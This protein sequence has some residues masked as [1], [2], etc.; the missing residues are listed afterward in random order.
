MRKFECEIVKKWKWIEEREKENPCLVGLRFEKEMRNERGN[1]NGNDERETV[2]RVCVV[3]IC[4]LCDWDELVIA[5][6]KDLIKKIL[7]LTSCMKF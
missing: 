4:W 6:N 5:I 3:F 1:G 7:Q 2:E